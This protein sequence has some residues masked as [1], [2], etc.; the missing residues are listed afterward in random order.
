ML[1]ITKR[2][3]TMNFIFGNNMM[4]CMRKGRVFIPDLV[5]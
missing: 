3:E 5:A 4:M 1:H 2:G